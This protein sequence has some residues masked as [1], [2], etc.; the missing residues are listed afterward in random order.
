MTKIPAILSATLTL[1]LA[2]CVKDHTPL[3]QPVTTP[4]VTPQAATVGTV[5][6]FN[7]TDG[8]FVTATPAADWDLRETRL[9][10]GLSVDRIPATK[11]GD[12]DVNRFRL[13]RKKP[14]ADGSM[15]YALPLVV[16]TGT[17]IFIS[18]YARLR[19]KAA[20]DREDAH[21]DHDGKH[22]DEHDDT[23]CDE[24]SG[25]SSAW[26][27]GTRFTETS[28]AMYLNY[29]VQAAAPPTLAGK[30][31]TESQ[32]S[33]GSLS[34]DGAPDYLMLMFFSAFP[35]GASIG[36]STGFRAQFT[37]AQAV[38]D[39]LPQA[40]QPA[41]LN[42]NVLNPRDLANPFAGAVLALTLNLGFDAADPA[43]C[44][45]SGALSDLV[46]A[47]PASSLYGLTVGEVLSMA[48]LTLA[49]RPDP[50]A[51]ELAELYDAVV[52]I[53]ANFEGGR[54]DAGFLGRP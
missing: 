6:V 35:Q 14:A 50:A 16:P 48:D 37:T 43:F 10:V 22:E 31:R 28:G 25:V 15:A 36:S 17:E 5:T 9:W 45:D 51:P 39:F 24:E 44:I 13:R 23:D 12:P 49:G 54:V 4:L 46:I 33:W 53:N 2:A 40:G 52:R 18:L 34:Q 11:S 21:D 38:A 19:P 7:S 1:S 42:R 30:F 3:G 20:R 29:T 47:D 27:L 41:P 26:A 32:E 8:L